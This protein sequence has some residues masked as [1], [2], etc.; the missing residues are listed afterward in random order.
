MSNAWLLRPLVMRFVDAECASTRQRDLRHQSPTLVLNRRALQ[1]ALLHRRDEPADV[2]ANQIELVQVVLL[3]WMH[4]DFRWRQSEDQPSAAN[5]HG[6]QLE[7][8]PEKQPVCLR[9]LAV[10]HGMSAC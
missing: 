9:V 2:L 10:D 6:G 3:R 8:I 5:V 4:G 1:A 7:N